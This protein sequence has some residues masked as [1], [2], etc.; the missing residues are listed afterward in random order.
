MGRSTTRTRTRRQIRN[1][2]NRQDVQRRRGHQ[3]INRDNSQPLR[4]LRVP[5]VR[6]QRPNGSGRARVLRQE[7]PAH[8]QQQRGEDHRLARQIHSGRRALS[9]Q[10]QILR[11]QQEQ[12]LL[13]GTC[14]TSGRCLV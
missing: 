12:R 4:L 3:H 2:P 14:P 1:R 13:R 10:I 11:S 7:P 8:S 6:E 5:S 9:Q